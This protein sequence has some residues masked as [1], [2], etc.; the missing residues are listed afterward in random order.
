MSTPPGKPVGPVDLSAYV[1]QKARERN[2]PERDPAE[3]DNANLRSPYAPRSVS[4]YAPKIGGERTGSAP[5]PAISG[6]DKL[7]SDEHD[8]HD[9][10]ASGGIAPGQPT[11]L[12]ALAARRSASAG[13]HAERDGP[14]AGRGDE[15]VL[16]E[17]DIE[18]LESSLRWLQREE[19]AARP[20]RTTREPAAH[21]AA[22][23][24][25]GESSNTSPRRLQS[26]RLLEPEHLVPPPELSSS[27]SRWPLAIMLASAFGAGVAYYFAAGDATP[28]STPTPRPQV[29]SFDSKTS[30]SSDAN[31]NAK[32]SAPPAPVSLDWQAFFPAVARDDD[33]AAASSPTELSSAR[34]KTSRLAKLPEPPTAAAPPTDVKLAPTSQAVRVLDP[35]EIKL[36]I[37]Q[38]EQFVAAGDLVTARVVFQRAAEADDASA[39][40]ALAATYDPAMVA[41]LGVV[42]LSGDIEKARSWYQKAESLGSPEATRRLGLLANR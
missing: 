10:P 30:A 25:I 36:L 38:G 29:A 16:I 35:E 42:G 6:P 15:Q 20:L 2:A 40:M 26:P 24:I 33:A 1:S 13:I 3:S 23:A 17:R 14:T 27:R 39:A 8:R 19:E 32:T 34:A 4:P 22:D 18:R 11:D 28:P 12:D 41:K 5:P 31:P 21:A 9:P 7:S 37:K